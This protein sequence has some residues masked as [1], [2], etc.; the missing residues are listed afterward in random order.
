MATPLTDNIHMKWQTIK[1]NGHYK[2]DKCEKFKNVTVGWG[3]PPPHK[4]RML[5]S[6]SNTEGW[7]PFE[8]S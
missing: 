2:H 8:S 6:C 3:L 4:K 7:V 5:H 1:A